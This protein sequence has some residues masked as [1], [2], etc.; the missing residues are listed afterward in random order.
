MSTATAPFYVTGGTLRPDAPSYVERQA[1]ADLYDGLTRGEF[2]YVLTA[3]QMGKSSLMARTAARLRQDG[4]AV[5]V[6][7]LTRVGQ[8]LTPEQWYDGLL[9]QAGEALDL[10]AELDDFW[11]DH[12]RLAPLQRWMEAVRQV[13]LARVPG[14]VTIFIDEIDAVRSLPFSADEFFAG[15]RECYNRRAEDPTYERLTF[16]LLGVASPSDLI[17]DTRITP[18]NIGRRIDLTDFTLAEAAPLAAGLAG[19]PEAQS[20]LQRILYW[21]AGHPYLTQRLCQAAAGGNVTTFSGV[22]ELCNDLFLSTQGR[23]RD[24]NLIFVREWLLRGDVDRATLLDFYGRVRRGQPVPAEETN[25]LVTFLRLSGVVRVADGRLALRNRIY[26]RVFDLAWVREHMPDA[27]LRR[28]RAAYRRGLARAAAVAAVVVAVI[29]SL[30]I[31]AV[32]FARRA[33]QQRGIANEQRLR[34][35]QRERIA[36][37]N[38]YAA[39]MMVAQQAYEEGGPFRAQQILNAWRPAAGS[40]DL[41]GF[42]WRYLWRLCEE[43]DAVQTWRGIA[44]A[45][46]GLALSPDGKLLAV[47]AADGTIRILDTAA[48]GPQASVIRSLSGHQGETFDVD[49]S[50]DGRYL[51]SGGAD[52]KV[53]VW[54]MTRRTAPVTLAG[55]SREVYAVGVSPDGR[56]VASGSEDGTIRLWDAASQR[57]IRTLR[58]PGG[59]IYSVVFSPAGKWLAAAGAGNLVEVWDHASARRVSL[60]KG[61][62][63]S[64]LSLCI[65]PDGRRLASASADRTIK[66]WDVDGKREIGTMWSDQGHF[67]SVAFSPDGRTLASGSTIVSLWDVATRRLL[68]TLKGHTEFVTSLVYSRDGERLFSAGRDGSIHLW[69]PGGEAR[70]RRLGRAEV[71]TA[72]VFSPDLRLIATGTGD[73]MIKLWDATSC[74]LVASLPG[75]TAPVARLAFS[76]DGRLLASGSLDRSVR[77]WDIASRRGVARISGY[78]A[79]MANYTQLPW[80]IAFSADGRSLALASADGTVKLWEISAK[81]ATGSVKGEGSVAF[82]PDGRLLVV[83]AREQIALW[84][85]ATQRLLGVMPGSP[86]PGHFLKFSPD[87]TRL[88]TG[89]WRALKLWDVQARRLLLTLQ[90]PLGGGAGVAFSPDGQTLAMGRGSVVRLFNLTSGQEVATLQGHQEWVLTLAFSP[91]GETLASASAAG[92]VRHWRATPFHETDRPEVT[93]TTGDRSVRLSWRPLPRASGYHVYRGPASAAL[94]QLTRLTP[95]PIQRTEFEERGSDVENEKARTYGVC[96]VQRGKDGR[97]SDGPITILEAVPI[98]IPGGYVACS[99]AEG[100]RSGSAR[101]DS[102]TGGIDLRGWGL[103]SYGDSDQCYFAGRRV[104]GDFTATVT[105]LTRPSRTRGYPDAGLMLRDSLAPDARNVF[106]PVTNMHGVHFNWRPAAGDD[107]TDQEVLSHASLKLPLTMRLVRRDSIV[108]AEISPDGGR[109]FRPAGKP[110]VFDPPLANSLHVGLAIASGELAGATQARFRDLRIEGPNVR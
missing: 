58:G 63:D 31:T 79:R 86:G 55:H 57:L 25:P 15:I 72:A 27:E 45:I 94:T 77:L 67:G 105:A 99:I 70:Q 39:Q 43:G 6:L 11:L 42:E 83:K 44:P 47:G 40:E 21:T 29:G 80:G 34:A 12:S 73:G 88:V 19:E 54:E 4:V 102:A 62:T 36:R 30:A 65:S 28:Q 108:H 95:Q 66:L 9:V 26:E 61:H 90:Q 14:R 46:D 38:L 37:R 17:R 100:P 71:F 10:E 35:E 98:A 103:G 96:A 93:A 7:D 33:D 107:T 110:Y 23:E 48:G 50:G 84:E 51:V 76:P 109:T 49:F 104:A 3:R 20:L 97:W 91:D 53:R 56:I 52:G 101:F 78:K 64:V 59:A 106:L 69:R 60:P 82:S 24:D 74:R 1:D 87:G 89:G 18:F 85:V 22:D 75:H 8:N 16:C 2:C 32:R 41:R 92:E 81:R 13:V 68:G 5:V